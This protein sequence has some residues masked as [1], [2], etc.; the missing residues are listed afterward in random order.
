MEG[1]G[2]EIRSSEEENHGGNAAAGTPSVVQNAAGE[3]EVHSTS[4]KDSIF[5]IPGLFKMRNKQAYTP[6]KFSIG[7]WHFGKTQELRAGQKWKESF[8]EQL[9]N[10]FSD[11]A[12]K[13]REL[14]ESIKNVCDNARECYVYD[15]GKNMDGAK[16]EFENILLLDGCFII[17]LLRRR[18]H[19]FRLS[20]DNYQFIYHDLL[21]LD[22]QIPW[23]VLELLFNKT[24]D[25]SDCPNQSLVEL[26]IEFFGP[27][28]PPYKSQRQLQIS[29]ILHL[30]DFV[31]YFLVGSRTKNMEGIFEWGCRLSI[32]SATRLEEAGIKFQ[33]IESEH[34][35]D[36]TFDKGVFKIP[37][38]RIDPLT[39]T[40]FRNLIIYEQCSNFAPRVTWY[41]VLLDCLVNTSDDVDLL[42]REEIFDNRISSEETANFFNRVCDNAV[43]T[44]FRYA[45]LCQDVNDYCKRRWPTWRASLIRNYF[46]KPWAIV[47]V[48]FATIVLHFTIMQVFYK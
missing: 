27:V 6:Y 28:I 40:I 8:L 19:P 30:V 29:N 18:S 34:P 33:K 43:M 31:W 32:P 1:Q 12:A 13:K 16:E 2:G 10:H 42:S 9:I 45:Q 11:P 23:F 5:R 21:L 46:T 24:N 15:A 35:L 38:L 4:S 37:W 47:S 17:E 25:Y 20:G 39:E 22:N 44:G 14:E 7:P 3:R 36:V 26:A 48:V 41:G